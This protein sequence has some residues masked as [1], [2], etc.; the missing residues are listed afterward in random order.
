MLFQS[1]YLK[2]TWGI[3]LFFIAVNPAIAQTSGARIS[4][5]VTSADGEG[6]PGVNVIL[7]DESK[8]TISHENGFFE[9]KNVDPGNHILQFVFLGFKTAEQEIVLK[10]GQNLQV[11]QPLEE[12]AY[13]LDEVQLQGKS[14][15]RKINE[16]AFAVSS[17]SAKALYNSTSDAKEVLDRVPGV[18]ILQEGG[19]GSNLS[20]SLN[21]FSGDQVKFF[22]DGIPMDNFGS[23]MSL[24]SIPV[25]SIERID[26][27]KGVVPVWLGTDALGGAVN[28]I[29]NQAHNFLDLSYSFGS[30][31]THRASLN[32]AYTDQKSGFTVRG[33]FNYNYSDN[34]YEI[35][36]DIRD[37][38][39]NFLETAKVDRFHDRYR[40]GMAQVETGFVD[41]KWADQLLVGMIASAD[42][43]EVQNGATMATP[44]GA[45]TSE[46]KSLVPTMKYKKQNLFADGLD[47]NLT[48][49]YNITET[50]NIDTLTGVRYNW[51]G[52]ALESNSSTD[53]ETGPASLVTLDDDEFTTQFNAGY[54]LNGKHSF[55]LN[56]AY[57]YFHR[58][59][60][61]EKNPDR[62][63]NQFPKSL[64]KQVLG[65][66]YKLDFNSKWSATLFGKAYLLNAE[67]SKQYGLTEN[68]IDIYEATKEN[69]GYGLATSYFLLPKLQLKTSYEHTYRMPWATEIFGDGLFVQPNA[70]LG[71]EQSDNFNIGANFEFS[72]AEDHNFKADG[73]FIYRNSEDLIYQVV[74]VASPETTYSNLAKSRTLG[75]EGSF[76]YSWRDFFRLGANVTYQN[77]TDQADQTYSDYSGYQTN[78]NKGA[79]LP[80]TP[81]LFGNATAGLTFKDALLEESLLNL[82]YYYNYVEEYY[83]GWSRYGNVEG[84]AVIPQQSSHSIEASYSLENGKYNISLECRN[85]TDEVL[86]DKYRLQKPGRAFYL[87]LRYVL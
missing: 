73:T 5:K 35:E 72:L 45:V 81:Y 62:I 69:T 26:V 33:N 41:K 66:S 38:N 12:G 80:N 16:Q 74:T 49:S 71:P 46:S 75:V 85:F 44:Y 48:S 18:R 56:Y 23:S 9:I 76:S 4:G 15:I 11:D 59:V 54:L 13:D 14:V 25:N 77:I 29:T 53:A 61:D 19:L 22:L 2:I 30:F 6:L 57:Q 3:L 60:F 52:E 70:D 31:N 28:I 8:G 1:R 42:D 43:D 34:D 17:V 47:V 55:A 37:V 83:L 67:S 86:Y 84:K 24:S 58:E 51:Y 79:R 32:A 68:T 39:G 65:L 63:Q 50:K 78:F 64:N 20:F 7:K 10:K 82:N 87:K 40:S 21:G 27:Y 36:A